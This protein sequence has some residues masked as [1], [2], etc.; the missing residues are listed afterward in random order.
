MT[1]RPD[2]V[3]TA[4]ALKDLQPTKVPLGGQISVEITVQNL[5]PGPAGESAFRVFLIDTVTGVSKDLKG[6]PSV[7]TLDPTKSK[8]V[9]GTLK[10]FSDTKL[11]TYT[12]RACADYGEVVAEIDEE[13]NC[14][15]GKDTIK[16]KAAVPAP[17][18]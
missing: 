1:E 15:M 11:G 2:L 6:H 7:S 8:V 17:A 4:V 18:P 12:L 13:N 3:V 10:V 9:K 14:A 5:G 16:I